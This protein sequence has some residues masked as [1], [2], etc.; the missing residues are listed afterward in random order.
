MRI[1]DTHLHLVYLDGSPI[2]GS[3]TR[4][5]CRT[6]SRSRLLR[7]GGARWGSR[8]ALHMEVDVAEPQMRGETDFVLDI[9]P[10]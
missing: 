6:G 5:T 3:P 7:R 9:D 10:R 1:L 8:S 4:R 2:P